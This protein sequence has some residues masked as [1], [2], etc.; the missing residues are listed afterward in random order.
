MNRFSKRANY[1]KSLE[2]NISKLDRKITVNTD[3]YMTYML[4]MGSALL[5]NARRDSLKRVL[6]ALGGFMC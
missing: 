4:T 1:I 5:Y 3:T 2:K 6:K